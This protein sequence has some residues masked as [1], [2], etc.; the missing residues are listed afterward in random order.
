VI[1]AIE[2]CDKSSQPSASCAMQVM[3]FHQSVTTFQ[4]SQATTISGRHRMETA[5][6]LAGLTDYEARHLVS[7]CVHAGR[8]ANAKSLLRLETPDQQRRTIACRKVTGSLRNSPLSGRRC[9]GGRGAAGLPPGTNVSGNWVVQLSA[10]RTEEE[11]QSAFRTAQA[12]YSVLASYQML[13]PFPDFAGKG[14]FAFGEQL[15][16]RPLLSGAA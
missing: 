15:T 4:R 1:F 16:L 2:P 13:R 14:R 7:H 11:A 6:S 9:R 5:S 12:K 10:Q 3:P 8:M